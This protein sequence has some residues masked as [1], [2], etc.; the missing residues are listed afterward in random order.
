MGDLN[1]LAYVKSTKISRS[2]LLPYWQWGKIRRALIILLDIHIKRYLELMPPALV[3]SESLM[4]WGQLPE[5]SN[6]SFKCANDDCMAFTNRQSS[7][8]WF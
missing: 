1:L 2:R 8:N 5:F 7:T 6:E 4:G 3:N